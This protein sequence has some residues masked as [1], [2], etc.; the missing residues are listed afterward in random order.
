MKAL[1]AIKPRTDYHGKG[2][3]SEATRF[4]SPR[5]SGSGVDPLGVFN[6]FMR[7][8]LVRNIDVHRDRLV[9]IDD[10]DSRK[11]SPAIGCTKVRQL[12]C[13]IREPVSYTLET[14]HISFNQETPLKQTGRSVLRPHKLNPNSRSPSEWAPYIPTQTQ[15]NCNSTSYD[16]IT[17][18]ERDHAVLRKATDIDARRAKGL[19]EYFDVTRLNHLNYSP[20]HRE[21]LASD[22]HYFHRRN[23][24][25]TYDYIAAHRFG[26][27]IM[28]F[29]KEEKVPG[30]PA[31]KL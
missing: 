17:F 29:E 7:N 27:M 9:R 16:F 30:K 20:Q 21:A 8:D 5:V 12:S 31:F 18:R 15:N 4:P 3:K 19:A 1:Q 6:G 14:D 2:I 10:L 24:R 26:N 28:P 13:P 23:G 11:N 25:F 22:R